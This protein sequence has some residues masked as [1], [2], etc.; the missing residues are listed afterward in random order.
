MKIKDITE[1]GIYWSKDY[2][3][4]PPK[5][6]ETYI[7]IIIELFS[8]IDQHNESIEDIEFLI[9]YLYYYWREDVINGCWYN[10]NIDKFAEFQIDRLALKLKYF[11]INFKIDKN[12]K[13]NF[14]INFKNCL[15]PNNEF[16]TDHKNEIVKFYNIFK[17]KLK[18]Y[19]KLLY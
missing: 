10:E 6:V 9:P 4:S 2:K 12:F 3:S 19:E 5:H 1:K 17:T 15:F 14:D 13:K 16:I 11:C 18:K 8:Y 7:A